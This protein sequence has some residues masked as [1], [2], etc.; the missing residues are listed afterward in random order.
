M[1]HQAVWL[2]GF[3]VWV[4]IAFVIFWLAIEVVHAFFVTCSW[5]RWT[6]KMHQL[7][8]LKLKW[9]KFPKTFLKR[10]GDFIGYRP[11]RTTIYDGRGFYWKGIG[12][13]KA[14]KVSRKAERS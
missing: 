12:D 8:D 7:N 10:W 2:T 4:A 3:L 14:G 6:I 11:G 5:C 9:G 1:I 13:W